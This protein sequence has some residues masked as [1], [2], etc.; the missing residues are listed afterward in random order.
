VSP[1]SRDP[2]FRA[3]TPLSFSFHPPMK[4]QP[5]ILST[6]IA[7]LAL[8]VGVDLFAADSRHAAVQQNIETYQRA[9]TARADRQD[10]QS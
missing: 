2:R 3:G 7:A 6:A 5:R 10:L 9:L 4:Y 8:N 1:S